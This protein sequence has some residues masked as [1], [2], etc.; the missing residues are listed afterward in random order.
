MNKKIVLTIFVK[1]EEEEKCIKTINEFVEEYGKR[2]REKSKRKT[3][4][5]MQI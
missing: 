5:N 2:R 3:E 1:K 4:A